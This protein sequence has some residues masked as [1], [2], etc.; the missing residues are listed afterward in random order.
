MTGVN[1]V[2]VP[3]KGLAPAIGDLLGGQIQVVFA[4]VG[5]VSSHIQGGKLR[6]LAITSAARLATL[7]DLPTVAESGV[8]GYSAGTWYGVLAPAATPPAVVSRLSEELRKVVALPEI[9]AAFASQGVAPAGNTP[10]QFAA[11]LREEYAKW[12]KLIRDAGIKAE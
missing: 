1:M 5:L 4:D 11:F 2:H 8:A 12:G 7:P 10:E 3:Y 9:R 6:G